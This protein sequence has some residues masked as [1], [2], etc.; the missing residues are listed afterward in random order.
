[1]TAVSKKIQRMVLLGGHLT[2][3]LAL[4][5]YI[6]ANH[7]DIKMTLIGRLYSQDRDKQ[8]SHEAK[9]AEKLEMTFVAFEAPRVSFMHFWEP[10]FFPFAFIKSVFT[11]IGL[12][13]TSKPDVVVS[14]GSYL[15]VPVSLA[16][17]LLKIPVVTHEQTRVPGQATHIISRFAKKIGVSFPEVQDSFPL[18]KTA[19]TGTPLRA[20]LLSP[21]SGTPTWFAKLKQ[22]PL[23]L[24]LGGNQGSSTINHVVGQALPQLVQEW[25]IVHQC[26]N[27]TANRNYKAELERARKKLPEEYQNRYHVAEWFS[28]QEL[29]W[30]LKK[31]VLVVSRSGANTVSELAVLKIP[32]IL[33]PLPTSRHQEQH[34]NALWLSQ[35]GGALL[36]PQKELSP[37]QLVE[38]VKKGYKKRAALRAALTKLHTPTDGAE[39]FYD[40]ITSAV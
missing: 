33:I 25:C 27:P 15:A 37:E 32:S 34:S 11:A 20:S 23:L 4:G 31:S 10:L 36:L 35:A 7:P 21:S 1:M 14:F 9:E 5:E 16:S 40:L 24:I 6:K 22:K 19:L 29:G 17:W 12:L 13:K 30:L 39:R 3:A 38:T 8:F 28:D 26:G 2:P 18:K